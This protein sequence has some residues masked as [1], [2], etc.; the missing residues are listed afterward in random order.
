M[1][2]LA[3]GALA[4][5]VGTLL[6]VFIGAGAVISSR[7]TAGA[8]LLTVAV[9][10]GLALAVCVTSFMYISGGQLNPAVAIG[11]IVA[12]QQS[13]LFG[14]VFI[15]A[16]L[17]G[18]AC[19]AGMLQ[20]LLT[21]DAANAPNVNLGATAGTFTTAGNWPGLIGIEAVCTFL[22]MTSVLVGTVDARAHKLGGFTIGLTVAAC[23]LFA[24]PLTGASMNPART[25][26]PAIC[27]RHWDLWWCYIV[28]PVLGAVLAA[29]A[30][31]TFW[32]TRPT[33]E[34]RAAKEPPYQPLAEGV[35][36]RIG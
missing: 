30:Y 16:Q 27:G 4:E 19:G 7:G 3:Q 17:L 36:H 29:L 22:L 8:Q 1:T 11:L 34:I 23:I 28:G 12:R 21:P 32:A 24:G 2:R 6:F 35:E 5:F 10:H 20:L 15:V 33:D 25:F 31:R 14:A 26:G 13:I 18:A 9:A